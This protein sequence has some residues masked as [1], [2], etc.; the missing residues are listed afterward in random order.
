MC[1][2]VTAEQSPTGLDSQHTSHLRCT[3]SD[4]VVSDEAAQHGRPPTTRAVIVRLVTATHPG[5][6]INGASTCA[7]AHVAKLLT[8][9][10]YVVLQTW[11]YTRCCLDLE[12][13][14]MDL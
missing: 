5:A 12:L 14:S 11:T 1:V 10:M 6:T 9:M 7:R 3:L 4:H 2:C 13:G 8:R